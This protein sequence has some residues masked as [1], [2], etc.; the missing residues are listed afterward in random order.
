MV[1]EKLITITQN[2]REIIVYFI[3]NITKNQEC[4]KDK[5]NIITHRLL[6][7]LHFERKISISIKTVVTESRELR[8]YIYKKE[9]KKRFN[10]ECVFTKTILKN[11]KMITLKKKVH[12]IIEN[13]SFEKI[14]ILKLT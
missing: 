1:L 14:K 9:K 2:V 5:A 11:D 7:R 13:N 8:W 3:K 10:S 4:I 12:G 6:I